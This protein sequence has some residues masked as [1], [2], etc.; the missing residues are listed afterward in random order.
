[1]FGC[2]LFHFLWDDSK[3]AQLLFSFLVHHVGVVFCLHFPWDAFYFT[4]PHQGPLIK[5]W[6][7]AWLSSFSFLPL[8]LCFRSSPVFGTCPGWV[9][10]FSL[11]LEGARNF[12]ECISTVIIY[13]SPLSLCQGCFLIPAFCHYAFSALSPLWSEP[14][15]TSISLSP[16]NTP[17]LKL[18]LMKFK[19]ESMYPYQED[20]CSITLDALKWVD[21]GIEK[22]IKQ[23]KL[24]S[25]DAD[26]KTP[27]PSP[28]PQRQR[29]S[30][31]NKDGT[32]GLTNF[33]NA[34]APRNIS[35]SI[36]KERETMFCYLMLRT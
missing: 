24:S 3:A 16:I 10:V 6:N 23:T 19:G 28:P 21:W 12:Q 1:M 35:I 29:V 13:L 17:T 2:Y 5:W 25:N 34:R 4:H 30:P 20:K 33:V 22:E 8:V 9:F 27:P 7:V 36:R 11:L 26:G 31:Y 15:S 32:R 18:L 14:L